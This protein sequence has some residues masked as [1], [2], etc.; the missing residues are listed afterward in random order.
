MSKSVFVLKVV[1][2]IQRKSVVVRKEERVGG[3]RGN[4]VIERGDKKVKAAVQIV[5]S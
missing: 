3:G 1:S 4:E 2:N 5:C